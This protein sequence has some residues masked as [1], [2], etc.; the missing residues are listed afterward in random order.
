MP[1]APT[2]VV[3]LAVV[4]VD[5]VRGAVSPV[6]VAQAG[7][8]EPEGDVSVVVVSS[9]GP[10]GGERRGGG[11]SH[12]SVNIVHVI[13]NNKVDIR[14]S[15]VELKRTLGGEFNQASFYQFTRLASRCNN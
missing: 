9:V 3:P 6:E 2:S 10:P 1:T 5:A 15:N 8:P 13:V 12:I 4:R 11:E 7:H 14:D